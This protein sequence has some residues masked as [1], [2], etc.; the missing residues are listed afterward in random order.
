[1][2]EKLIR[3]RRHVIEPAYDGSRRKGPVL[4]LGKA[5]RKSATSLW[6]F[7]H[8][9]SAIYL[10]STFSCQE[11]AC[12]RALLTLVM[13]STPVVLSQSSKALEPCLA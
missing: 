5:T 11:W 6:R 13:F 4:K 7:F 1:V 3:N 8:E 10:D 9:Q 2:V 12:L